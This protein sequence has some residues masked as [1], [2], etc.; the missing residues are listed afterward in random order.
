MGAV[1]R[2]EAFLAQT[3][4]RHRAVRAE[5]A[6]G[7]QVA[8]AALPG[9]DAA[10]VVRAWSTVEGRLRDLEGK[11]IDTW[12]EKVAAAFSAED[13]DADTCDAAYQKGAR[14]DFDLQMA[15]EELE[16]DIVAG[17][18][19]EL[20]AR[21]LAERRD[22]FC[23]GCGAALAIPMSFRALELNCPGCQARVLFEPGAAARAA[24]SVGAHALPQLMARAPWRAMREAERRFRE[25]R[26]PRPLALV[27]QHER[28]QLAYWRA[29]LAARAE[30]EPELSRD[31]VLEVR[32][33]M[34][35]FY[36]DVAEQEP[37]WVEA[38]R[39]R[40]DL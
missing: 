19:R 25:W 12:H 30:I 23:T 10:P 9:A 34:E 39:P 29:Y 40:D 4:G 2:W 3:E 7:A 14:L 17:C 1:A 37:A 6:Q 24:G 35:P 22:R 28:A 16:V 33:R 26:P 20:F 18:A 36:L 31:P 38:G 13:A 15:R 8:I 21:A 5:A 11:I 32:A 27:K